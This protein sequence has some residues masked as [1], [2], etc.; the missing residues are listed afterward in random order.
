MGR[1]HAPIGK[2]PTKVEK[3]YARGNRWLTQVRTPDSRIKTNYLFFVMLLCW[4]LMSN[5]KQIVLWDP[6]KAMPIM[7]EVGVM[8]DLDKTYLCAKFKPVW[9]SQ[10]MPFH[11]YKYILLNRPTRDQ[12]LVVFRLK[13]MSHHW[14]ISGLTVILFLWSMTL[15]FTD[16]RSQNFFFFLISPSF[17]LWWEYWGETV[18][19]ALI[20]LRMTTCKTYYQH[21]AWA[22]R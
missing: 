4:C 5:Y 19:R 22:I 3:Q 15:K 1:T 13:D 6:P 20:I 17:S 21:R 7:K 2:K 10:V 9:S 12:F 11:P 16:L 18:K 8:R 14:V